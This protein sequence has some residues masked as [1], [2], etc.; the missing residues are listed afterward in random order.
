MLARVTFCYFQPKDLECDSLY[1]IDAK[2]ILWQSSG[3]CIIL[4]YKMI[5]TATGEIPF[6][7]IYKL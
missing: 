5:Q 2:I 4:N 1:I 3:L 7:E 6:K